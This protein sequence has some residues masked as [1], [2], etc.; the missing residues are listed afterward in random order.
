MGFSWLNKG[1]AIDIVCQRLNSL[2]D[3]N[4]QIITQSSLGNFKDKSSINN[5]LLCKSEIAYDY[6]HRC[7]KANLLLKSVNGKE[8]LFS[9]NDCAG[10]IKLADQINEFREEKDSSAQASL[11]LKLD[12]RKSSSLYGTLLI[13][14]GALFVLIFF[15]SS[16]SSK[17]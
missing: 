1:K 6:K 14:L 3:I 9:S 7:V 17:S 13:C 8:F 12:N 5:L 2:A 16:F 4:C 11:R 10:I 15:G